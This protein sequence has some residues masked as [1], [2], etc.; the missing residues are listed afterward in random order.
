[1]VSRGWNGMVCRGAITGDFARMKDLLNDMV[2][3][4]GLESCNVRKNA[5]ETGNLSQCARFVLY[6]LLHLWLHYC[7]LIH[8]SPRCKTTVYVGH[9]TCLILFG[10]SSAFSFAVQ[11]SSPKATLAYA[12]EALY[13][14]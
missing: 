14:A 5:G 4:C 7:L 12:Q 3:K 1:M 8:G 10:V 13:P 6:V 2:D 9:C 11:R